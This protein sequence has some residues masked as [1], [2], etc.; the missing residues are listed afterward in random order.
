MEIMWKSV[1]KKSGT[2]NYQSMTVSL[3]HIVPEILRRV[4]KLKAKAD[5]IKVLSEKSRLT[6]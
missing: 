4:N 5:R 6:C 2:E 3:Q 1:G